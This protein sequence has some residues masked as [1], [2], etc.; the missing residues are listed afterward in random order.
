MDISRL[1]ANI[2]QAN[3]ISFDLGS[4]LAKIEPQFRLDALRNGLSL[5]IQKNRHIVF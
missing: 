4:L 1:D 2:V 5:Y 3:K